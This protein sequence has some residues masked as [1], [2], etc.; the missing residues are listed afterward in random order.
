MIG[1]APKYLYMTSSSS[2]L[3]TVTNDDSATPLS[4]TGSFPRQNRQHINIKEHLLVFVRQHHSTP[5]SVR[6]TINFSTFYQF[7]RSLHSLPSLGNNQHNNVTWIHH[8]VWPVWGGEWDCELWHSGERVPDC[9]PDPPL[10]FPPTR[11]PHGP[12]G[13]GQERGGSGRQ[14]L[15]LAVLAGHCCDAGYSSLTDWQFVR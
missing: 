3:T 5:F 6:S 2:K 14:G 7:F 9:R 15:A 12:C 10:S 13:V 11:R 1:L 8:P 4:V